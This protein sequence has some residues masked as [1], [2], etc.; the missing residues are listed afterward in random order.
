MWPTW[1]HIRYT[2]VCLT[3]MGVCL[4]LWTSTAPD[5]SRPPEP[6]CPQGRFVT[7]N[8]GGRL[9]NKLCQYCSLW[10]LQRDSA[11][12]RPAW[13]LPEMERSL[14]SLF[15]GLQLPTLP[16]RCLERHQ[17]PWYDPILHPWSS[18]AFWQ[19][20]YFQY[21]KTG[22]GPPHRP[23][24]LLNNP[25]DM[26]HFDQHRTEL[27]E[28]LRLRPEVRDEAQRRLRL[29]TDVQCRRPPGCTFIGVHVRRTDYAKQVHLMYDGTLVGEAYLMRA[30]QLC[31]SRYRRP[32]FV[33]CSDNLAWVRQR[34]RGPD[35]VIA[36]SSGDGSAGRD[37]ALLAQC[38]HTVVTHGTY[39]YMSAYL[40]QGD[41][42]APTGFGRRDA[43]LAEAMTKRGLNITA[44]QAF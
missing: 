10:A 6:G 14:G 4:V 27:L 30:L 16:A 19:V 39:G 3:I 23:L 21:V 34:L 28:Q 5:H 25:C 37:M 26:K 9:G 29:H 41:V 22:G 2:V 11:A 7:I 1:R 8:A 44:V 35:I 40:A 24:L 20:S 17:V 42:L 32:V 15:T 12:A 33:V 38:N 43:F 18:A 31:R 36:G 13:I